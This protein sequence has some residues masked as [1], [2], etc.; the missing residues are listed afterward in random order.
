[1]CLLKILTFKA[2]RITYDSW[3]MI[4]TYAYIHTCNSGGV[5]NDSSSCCWF[6]SPCTWFSSPSL[7]EAFVG[8]GSRHVSLRKEVGRQNEATHSIGHTGKP[9][10]GNPQAD[11]PGRATGWRDS[12][13][14]Q[15]QATVSS[16]NHVSWAKGPATGLPRNSVIPQSKG[17]EWLSS[18]RPMESS[19]GRSERKKDVVREQPL[20]SDQSARPCVSDTLSQASEPNTTRRCRDTA[21]QTAGRGR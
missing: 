3:N 19:G 7:R 8:L 18:Q 20:G 12:F 14:K 4:L 1:M 21:P 9:G 5:W 16:G 17:C 6:A 11:R 15:G 13:S 2:C 10:T